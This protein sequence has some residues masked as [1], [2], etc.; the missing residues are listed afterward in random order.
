[1]NRNLKNT[2]FLI[3]LV[4]LSQLTFNI[5]AISRTEGQANVKIVSHNAFLTS[6]SFLVIGEVENEGTMNVTNITIK[7]NFYNDRWQLIDTQEKPTVLDVLL[8]GRKT[9]FIFYGPHEAKHYDVNIESYAPHAEGKPLALEILE[10][11]VF[12]EENIVWGI[13]KNIGTANT[14][15]IIVTATFYDR[16]GNVASMSSDTSIALEQVPPET[17]VDFGIS[18]YPPD[19]REDFKMYSITAE[20]RE[21]SIKQEMDKIPLSEIEENGQN[22]LISVAIIST[23]I[24]LIAAFLILKERRKKRRKLIRT[25][26]RK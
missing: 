20:S 18:I 5:V 12:F 6:T 16:Y 4:A 2:T 15:M 26:I 25:K 22:P 7:A 3:L 19:R 14:S 8:I 9:P 10:H 13:I 17:A 21:Y 11:Q 23:T 1:M 24:I